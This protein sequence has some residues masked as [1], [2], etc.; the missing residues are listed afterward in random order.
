MSQD[1]IR[2][3]KDAIAECDRFISKED[4]RNPSLRPSEATQLLSF[5]IEHKATL[6]GMLK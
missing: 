1:H 3:I 5:Y 6:E 2:R 4:V